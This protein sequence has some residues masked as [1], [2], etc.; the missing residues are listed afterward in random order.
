M[1]VQMHCYLIHT[2]NTDKQ[3]IHSD[4]L[5]LVVIAEVLIQNLLFNR[6]LQLILHRKNK[7]T[8]RLYSLT[9][10]E[11]QVPCR[12]SNWEQSDAGTVEGLSE[13]KQSFI[14]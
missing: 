11:K 13:S 6:I 9:N 7:G 14:L 3:R 10:D 2:I 5:N 4:Q 1:R 12:I 8:I